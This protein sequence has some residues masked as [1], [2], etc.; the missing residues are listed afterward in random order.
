M[1]QII[2][3]G[4]LVLAFSFSA[5][6]QNK[7]TNSVPVKSEMSLMTPEVAVQKNVN[8]LTAFVSVTPE[9]KAMLLE[10][11]STKYRMFSADSSEQNKSYVSQVIARKLEATLEP[12]TFKKLRE[13]DALFQSLIK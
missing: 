6:A 11:F 12:A 1:K 8:D 3:A 2:T 9:T 13:N 7:K 4:V 10:L 5:S